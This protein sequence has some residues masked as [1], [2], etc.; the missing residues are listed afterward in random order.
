MLP[1]KKSWLFVPIVLL[2]VAAFTFLSLPDL[3]ILM[4]DRFEFM[5][6]HARLRDDAIVTAA[7]PAVVAIEASVANA[8]SHSVRQGTGF[9]LSPQG[10][11]IT[12]LHIVEDASKIK[13]TFGNGQTFIVDHIALSQ[14]MIWP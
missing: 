7:K 6:D 12:N 1:K 5:S 9:N 8:L 4:A 13:I 2:L 14:A 10:R 3:Q 11:I